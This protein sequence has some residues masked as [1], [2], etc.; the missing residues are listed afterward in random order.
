MTHGRRLATV[1]AAIAIAGTVAACSSGTST[2]AADSKTIAAAAVTSASA[3][4]S[5]ANPC[6]TASGTVTWYTSQDAASTATMATAFSKVCPAIKVSVQQA[7][8]LP[9]MQRFQQ[10]QAAGDHK[11]DVLSEAGYGLFQQAL[12]SKLI[13]PIP[14]SVLQGYPSQ[15]VQPQDYGFSN[16]IITTTIVVN[17]NM[18][19]AGSEPKSWA[20]LLSPQWKGKIALTDPTQNGTAYIAL[21]QMLHTSSLGQSFIDGLAKQKPVM[22]TTTGQLVNALVTG[23]YSVAIVAEDNAWQQLATGAPLKVINPTEGDSTNPNYN[24]LVKTAPNPAAAN[25]FLAWL[26]GKDGAQVGATATGDYSAYPDVTPPPSTR[27][28]FGQL[29]LLTRDDAQEATDQATVSQ[30]FFTTLKNG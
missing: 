1:I 27:V 22:L 21:W 29:K 20:D 16:R 14:A 18:V 8:A 13:S 5:P 23:E 10:E 7:A 11:A 30:Q 15:W 24:M 6:G 3:A 17:T 9:L 26:A 25:A 19:K 4:P 28:P 12:D 2:N